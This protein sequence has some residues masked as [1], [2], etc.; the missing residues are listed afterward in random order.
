MPLP[1]RWSP[2]RQ[3]G[4][5]RFG[6]DPFADVEQMFREFG[7]APFAGGIERERAL[8]MRLDVNED[9][10][11]YIVN[12]DMPG[13]RKDDIDIAVEGN[14]VTISAEVKR[15]DK[16]KE[17]KQKSVHSERFYGK[18]CRSFTLPMEI[19]S[20]KAEAA[21]DGGVLT[22]SLPKLHEGIASRRIT[23]S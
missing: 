19:D 3:T 13:V 11:A 15:G 8:E 18:A 1:S 14:Q 10:Q 17:G 2:F 21:Y 6:S 5:A 12:V 22:L 4:S 9:D 16:D 20:S 23:V 7:L